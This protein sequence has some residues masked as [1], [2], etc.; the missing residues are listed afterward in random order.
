MPGF[1]KEVTNRR[2][3]FSIFTTEKSKPPGVPVTQQIRFGIAMGIG[4]FGRI[5]LIPDWN[6]LGSLSIRMCGINQTEA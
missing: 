5:L 4:S 2:S 1:R 3:G 6:L